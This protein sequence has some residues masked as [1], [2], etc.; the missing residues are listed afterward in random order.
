MYRNLFWCSLKEIEIKESESKLES[1]EASRDTK[2]NELDG[3]LN[4]NKGMTIPY[5][6]G[7][8]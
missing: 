3:L 1:V 7:D 5:E 8:K 4:A 6:S 2:I